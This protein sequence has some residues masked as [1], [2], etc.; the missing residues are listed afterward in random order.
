MEQWPTE[1]PPRRGALMV[2]VRR[3]SSRFCGQRY[4]GYRVLW[5]T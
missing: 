5:V 1:R 2:I 4:C 3:D